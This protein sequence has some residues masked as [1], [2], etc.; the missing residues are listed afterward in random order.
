LA[1]TG[2]PTAT[3][4]SVAAVPSHFHVRVI[5]ASAAFWSDPVDVLGRVLDVAGLAVDAVLGVDLQSRLTAR[6]LDKFINSCGAISLLRPGIDR[7]VDGRGYVGVLERQMNRLVLLMVGVGHEH[8]RKTIE[9]ERSIRLGIGYRR[10]LGL[11]REGRVVGLEAQR[12]RQSQSEITEPHVEPGVERPRDTAPVRHRGLH[13]ANQ[14]ELADDPARMD[15]ALVAVEHVAAAIVGDRLESGLGGEHR[16]LHRR[17]RALDPRH[18]HEPRRAA[19]ERSAG[20]DELGD[21]LVPALVDRA[22]AVGHAP[23]A[24]DLGADRRMGLPALEFLERRKIGVRIIERDDEAERDLVVLLMV[25]EAPAPGIGQRPALRVDHSPW[26]M[27][28]GR[29]VPQLLDAQP[30]YL[31]A[32]LIAQV[33]D[34]GQP[35]GQRAPG[36]FRKEGVASVKLDPRLVVGTMAAVAGDAH[37]SGRDPLHRSVVVEQDFG[38]RKSGED[39]DAQLFRLA[40]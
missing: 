5:G 40:G 9:S 24:L 36:S 13:V 3:R 39:F 7:Q 14:L 15:R 35:L 18:V 21:G 30:E 26:L 27:L 11:G 1:A 33:E 25:E 16:R 17:M 38:G 19:D 2:V 28:L 10:R 34:I 32:T 12:P 37:V 29:N 22:R 8:R 6:L 31:R 23:P 4:A 20:E